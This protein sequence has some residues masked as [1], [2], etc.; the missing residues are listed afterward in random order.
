M[1]KVTGF[2]EYTRELP[3]AARP[4]SASSDWFEIY[5][6]F[7]EEQ[8]AHAG[9]A[10]H[11][12]RRA[13][14]PHRLPAQQHHSRL[15]RPGL[16]RPLARSRA[17]AACHQQFPGIHRPHL[18]RA[19][20]SGLRAGHQRAAGHHQ[21]DRKDHRRPRLRGGLDPP[22]AAARPH[23]QARGRGRFRAR[24]PGR[25]AATGARRPRGHRLREDRPHRRPAALRHSQFQDGEA[26]HRPPPGAD[27]RRRSALRHQRP[28]GRE[29]PGGRPA[30]ASSTPCCWPAAP[31]SR[32]ICAFPAA[33]SPAFTSPWSFCRS[34]TG[35]RGRRSPRSQILATGKRVVIIGG[36]DTGADCLGT[37]HRQGARSVTS[38]SCCPSRRTSARPPRR[39]R[40]GPCS[41]AS[42]AR[43]KRAACATGAFPPCNSPATSTAT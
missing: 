5:Q 2:L 33:S 40:S 34:R 10:L 28:R 22:R 31:S 36:G 39:G 27:A 30:H 29:R 25:G 35:A 32:A 18:S 12:L 3:R 8:I 13:L 20:R 21:A 42:K 17:P 7:P 1:G 26:P 6:P 38:S 23:R 14:L 11:G 43:T 9:R 16:P 24:R 19:V 15:E 41:C 4:P 37:C